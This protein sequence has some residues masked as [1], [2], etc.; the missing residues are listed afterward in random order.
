MDP[1]V[2]IKYG[3]ATYRTRV[4]RHDLNPSWGDKFIL[5]VKR[6]TPASASGTLSSLDA[7]EDPVVSIQLLDWE[8]IGK[9]ELIG[10]AMLELQ[11]F[12]DEAP[13]PD[14]ETAL[15]NEEAMRVHMFKDISIPVTL[16]HKKE[17]WEANSSAVIVLRYV[18]HVFSLS[19]TTINSLRHSVSSMSRTTQ[20]GSVF[21]VPT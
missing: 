7:V 3:G 5:P 10:T 9:D 4:V 15:Y 11:G 12:I 19:F 8:Q 1:F 6:A 16:E 17:R 2:V 13:K 14:P 18:T 21:G 20:C